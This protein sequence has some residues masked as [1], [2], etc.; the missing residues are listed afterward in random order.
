MEECYFCVFVRERENK[1]GE[2]FFQSLP[3][4]VLFFKQMIISYFEWEKPFQSVIARWTLALEH[5]IAI[6][7]SFP[8][9]V[10]VSVQ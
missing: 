9:G 3:F 8:A 1:H 7:S 6:D 10:I 2:I 4:I 5:G